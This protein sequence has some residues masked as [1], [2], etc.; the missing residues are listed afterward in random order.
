MEYES[1]EIVSAVI[2]IFSAFFLMSL[3]ILIFVYFSRK[4]IIEKEIKNKDLQLEHQRTLLR[5]VIEAQE[6]ER[7]RIAQDLHDDISSGLS[8]VSLNC[9]ILKNPDLSPTEQHQISNTILSLTSKVLENSRR[10]AHD[11]LPPIIEK[12]GIQAGIEE[13]VEDLNA[14]KKVTIKFKNDFD[15][16]AIDIEKHLHLFRIIQE[17]INNSMRHG[18]ADAIKIH[19]TEE[20]AKKMF[21]YEDNGV[22]FDIS[23]H[24]SQKGL[25]MKNI[26]S[27]VAFIGGS[28]NIISEINKGTQVTIHF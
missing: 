22:G 11:L 3:S 4:K 12:F 9:H 20:D 27:R 10:I 8:V 18:K 14:T 24:Q 26:E 21:Y 28:Y 25:G 23:S 6:K 16:K 13:L 17:L 7:S 15:L 5:A 19:I 2:Y 1:S